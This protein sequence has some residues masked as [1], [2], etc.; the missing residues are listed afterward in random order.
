[1][2]P[3][4]LW[5]HVPC[6][7]CSGET[8]ITALPWVSRN[9]AQCSEP[10][11][12]F[13][14]GRALA[15]PLFRIRR[16][17]LAS[18]SCGLCEKARAVGASPVSRTTSGGGG[19]GVACCEPHPFP[20]PS[21]PRF[22]VAGRPQWASRAASHKDA[23]AGGSR[24]SHLPLQDRPRVNCLSPL[25]R[26]PLQPAVPH[27]AWKP[28]W[29]RGRGR[30]GTRGTESEFWLTTPSLLTLPLPE[31]TGGD[32]GGCSCF[33]G[34]SQASRGQPGPG[35][36]SWLEQRPGGPPAPHRTSTGPRGQWRHTL[37][38]S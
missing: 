22:P 10:F 27:S 34:H 9:Q 13:P 6:C 12:Y 15:V 18:G 3:T 26:V 8:L 35:S 1:M 19:L 32:R 24:Y 29:K 37:F 7:P 4:S 33:A 23:E 5:A 16:S 30:E 14:E 21:D 11:I 2:P 25:G 36:Q 28:W 17:E 38:L 20:S 31:V